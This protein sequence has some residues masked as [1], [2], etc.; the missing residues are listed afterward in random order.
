MKPI[1]PDVEATIEQGFRDAIQSVKDGKAST[2]IMTIEAFAGEPEAFY[3][4][5]W[6]A[7]SK[8]VDVTLG[9]PRKGVVDPSTN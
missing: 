9:A 1:P 7:H 4:H 8:G 2:V 5:M 3:N 6:Y